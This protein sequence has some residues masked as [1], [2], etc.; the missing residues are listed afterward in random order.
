MRCRGKVCTLWAAV[1]CSTNTNT[2]STST[3]NNSSNSNNNRNRSTS[4][5][6]RRQR[7]RSPHRHPMASSPLSPPSQTVA[8]S[9]LPVPPPRPSL[10][11][12]CNRQ[13][14]RA[15]SLKGFSRIYLDRS[16]RGQ[17]LRRINITTTTTITSMGGGSRHLGLS[18]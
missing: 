16:Y 10:P 11:L 6:P 7:R 1:G 4:S 12:L 17:T 13:S 14:L 9:H 2:N 5:G 15:N 18:S 8:Q 3:S